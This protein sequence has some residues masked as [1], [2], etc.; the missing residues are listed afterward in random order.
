MINRIVFG[1][2]RDDPLL[3][4][5]DHVPYFSDIEIQVAELENEG[6]NERE[7]A[8]NLGIDQQRVSEIK[9][10]IREKAMEILRGS[11]GIWL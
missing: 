6:K 4:V 1:C 5:I 2:E 10:R 11:D 8:E 7:I 3:S 9:N